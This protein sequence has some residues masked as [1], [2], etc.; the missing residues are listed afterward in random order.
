MTNY[1]SRNHPKA[2]AITAGI[3]AFSVASIIGYQWYTHPSEIKSTTLEW[4]Y[5]TPFSI[6]EA[7]PSINNVISQ[8]IIQGNVNPHQLGKQT[9]TVEVKKKQAGIVQTKFIV[10]VVDKTAPTIQ[11]PAVIPVEVNSS[12]DIKAYVKATDNVDGD[13]TERLSVGAYNTDTV[14]EQTVELSVEDLSKNQTKK[15]VQLMVVDTEPMTI[16]FDN[17]SIPYQNGGETN[18]QSI[19][20]K[21][22][23]ASTWGGT[24]PF[25][26]TDQQNTHFIG[27][28]PGVFTDIWKT[29]SFIITD[30]KNQPF[31]YQVT[32]VYQ[33][34]DHGI[35]VEDGVNYWSRIT[36]TDGGERVVFQTCESDTINY[37]VEAELQK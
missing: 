18:G 15:T 2:V 28:S 25:N 20:D 4:A 22:T 31:L 11:V 14:G 33:V 23:M 29:G 36:G 13:V 35:G 7:I 21:G 24:T 37:I 26:G 34:D 1:L 30:E 27:H 16:Y 32:N 17:K 6:Q 19:I 3:L 9:I 12:F 8:K 10:N 5:G